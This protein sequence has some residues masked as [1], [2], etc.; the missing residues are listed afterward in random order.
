MDGCCYYPPIEIKSQK[1]WT[2]T[3]QAPNMVGM[4]CIQGLVGLTDNK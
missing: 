1:S 3:D 4:K 2:H